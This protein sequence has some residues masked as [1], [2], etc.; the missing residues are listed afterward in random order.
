MRGTDPVPVLTVCR[1]NDE[2]TNNV[3]LLRCKK[4]V[5][6]ANS[7]G[8]LGVSLAVDIGGTFTDVVLRRGAEL[9]IDD[10]R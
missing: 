3:T 2:N 8:A 4:Q 9:F 1:R 6:I 5:S 10:P 7:G